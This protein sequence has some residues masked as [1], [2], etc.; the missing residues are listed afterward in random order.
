MDRTGWTAVVL[1]AIALVLWQ[2]YV[3]KQ[4]QTHRPAT[5]SSPLPSA[6]VSVTPLAA[7]PLG[8]SVTPTITATPSPQPA[9]SAAEFAEATETLKNSDVELHLTNRGGGISEVV[10]PKHLAENDRQVV[11]NGSAHMPIGAIVADPAAP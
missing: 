1:C 3:V 10:L 2:F 11:L 8:P 4:A 7:S 5:A 9:P 6:S